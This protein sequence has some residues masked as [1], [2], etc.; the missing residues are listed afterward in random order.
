MRRKQFEDTA[1]DADRWLVSY[2]DF[3]TLIFAFFVMMYS[4]SSVQEKKLLALSHSVGQALGLKANNHQ[5]LEMQQTMTMSVPLPEPLLP[6]EHLPINP[7]QLVE[8]PEPLEVWQ[9]T[10]LS[11]QSLPEPVSEQQQHSQ[12][13]QQRFLQH[14][15]AMTQIADQLRSRFA[16]LIAEGKIHVVQS[17][18]GI[19]IEVNASLL[20]A[21]ADAKLSTASIQTLKSIADLLKKPGYKIRVE[22]HTD[23]KP[24]KTPYFPS[25]WELSSARATGVLRHLIDLGI[26]GSRL[27]AVGYAD[28]RALSDN[29]SGEGRNRNRRVQLMVFA[30]DNADPTAD[31]NGVN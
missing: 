20:F 29:Q 23:N 1:E 27:S 11:R 9:A 19:S 15:Q 13:Q 12:L 8:L 14:Q 2:A 22:G 3:I 26:E 4:V 17:S 10:A 31:Y 18:W 6:A 7:I 16:D 5:G 25:N 21:P 24:I 30:E 28:T